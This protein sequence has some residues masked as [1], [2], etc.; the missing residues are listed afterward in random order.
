[1]LEQMIVDTLVVIGLFILRIGVPLTI[2]FGMAAWLERKLQS[3]ERCETNRRASGAQI[4]PFI[5]PR[6]ESDIPARAPA[7][8][9]VEDTVKRADSK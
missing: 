4:I 5:K 2:L 9:S 1:M 3:P 8:R 6:Q 7:P